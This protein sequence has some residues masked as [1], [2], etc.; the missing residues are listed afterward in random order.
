MTFPHEH[1]YL[2]EDEQILANAKKSGW[3]LA[4]T[5]VM[6]GI[7]IISG[8]LTHSMALLADGWHMASHSC[9]MLISLFAYRLGRSTH[10]SKR[11]SFGA[12]KFI[13][14]GGYTSALILA[15]IA[16]LMS[17]ESVQRL[18][19]PQAIQFNEAIG[20]A[21]LGL[22][23]NLVSAWI[24]EGGAHHHDQGNDD[25]DHHHNHHHDHN[26]RSAYVHVLADA[27]TS[28]LAIIALFVG[29]FYGLNWMDPIMGIVG[30]LVI[31]K[32]AYDLCRNTASELLDVHSTQAPPHRIRA[33]L[34]KEGISV[35]DVHTWRIAPSAVACE[36]VVGTSNL[37]GG[38]FYRR[39]IFTKFDFRHL[40]IEERLLS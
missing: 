35:L 13:P 27:L 5:G 33:L 22:C 32:W 30:S 34:E 19:S 17:V 24:L 7:E 14:L 39:I 8:Y 36:L 11:L 31:L 10:L 25:H 15:M 1:H 40:V 4:L 2:L 3:V 37:R 38:D 9:A 6:M 12:G 21:A 28:I 26:L 18:L 16:V 23:V 20:I 29:K